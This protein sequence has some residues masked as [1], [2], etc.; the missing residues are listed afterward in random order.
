MD[1]VTLYL[2]S[3]GTHAVHPVDAREILAASGEEY[4]LLPWP[5]DGAVREVKLLIAG[6]SPETLAALGEAGVESEVWLAEKSWEWVL[7]TYESLLTDERERQALQGWHALQGSRLK[8]DSASLG[9]V[10]PPAAKASG[11][12][13][14]GAA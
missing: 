4:A 5:A 7:L 1:L 6:V 14:K 8:R 3:G 2:R 12:G 13:K 11:R 10:T 9:T